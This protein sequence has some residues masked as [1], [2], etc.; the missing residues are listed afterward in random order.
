MKSKITALIISVIMLISV[1]SVSAFA[2][3]SEITNEITQNY[4]NA[5]SIAGKRSFH[6]NCNL[7]TA[8]QLRAIG[9]YADD[10]DYSGTGSSW[11]SYFQNVSK[12]TGGYNVVTISGKDCL[13]DLTEKYGDEIYNIVYSLG[14]GGSSGSN[15]VLY[16][17]AIID[18]YVYFCDSFGT[19]Y[20]H[21]SYSEGEG[22][23]LPIDTFV[24]E[25]KR[26]NGN[27]YGCV[28]FTE[29]RS[30][31][32]EG[33]AENPAYWEFS[34]KYA[35]GK[36]I[37][38]TPS[39]KLRSKPDS[40]AK[41]LAT[42]LRNEQ[43]TVTEVKGNWGKLEWN[44]TYVWANLNFTHKLSGTAE[45]GNYLSIVSLTAN[46]AGP[47]AQNKIIWTANV[48][49]NNSNKY[50]YAFYIYKDNQKIYSGTFSTENTVSFTPD[51][52]GIYKASVTVIDTHGNIASQISNAVSYFNNVIYVD[53]HDNDG[54]ITNADRKLHAQTITAIET[55][56]GRN[57]VCDKVEKDGVMSVQSKNLLPEIPEEDI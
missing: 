54:L 22:I 52:Q 6:G 25:Y 42:I 4:R 20:N 35:P 23:V 57:F 37:V 30:E 14:T 34:E 8:Y 3:D 55:I 46:S 45:S 51:S 13:Y 2:Y 28:Y 10:L 24:S 16:I 11:H 38:A 53:D 43:I 18:G 56:T 41:S 50:F 29:G 40:S 33:S 27:A 15:H 39:L 48:Q 12:T 21:V 49:G 26:M 17:R 9:I 47:L 1:F 31:H 44:G 5:L 7:A 19:N 36:Y 32:L